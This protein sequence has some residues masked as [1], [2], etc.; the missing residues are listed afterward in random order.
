M[1]K[2][3]DGNFDVL[4]QLV[5]CTHNPNSLKKVVE[6]LSSHPQSQK[7]LL[8]RK[9]LGDVNLD[10][11]SV[12]P[13]N[14]LGYLYAHQLQKNGQIPYKFKAAEDEY[15]FV[16]NHI[17]ET[18]DLWHIVIDADTTIFGE[19]Q[20]EAFYVAPARIFSILAIFVS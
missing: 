9:G 10:K 16:K 14:T 2:T 4:K 19:I 15:Q 7:A 1:V 18:H 13:K 17:T 12:L 20:L 8:E 11:L 5:E 6:F 3:R